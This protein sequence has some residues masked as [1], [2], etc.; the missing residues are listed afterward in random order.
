MRDFAVVQMPKINAGVPSSESYSW[1]STLRAN[2]AASQQLCRN[3]SGLHLFSQA[4]ED[5]QLLWWGEKK[6]TIN[7]AMIPPFFYILTH[8]YRT[9]WKFLSTLPN[10]SEQHYGFVPNDGCQDEVFK[11][12]LTS[13]FN[14]GTIFNACLHEIGISRLLL[15]RTGN[16][17][18]I[19]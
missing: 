17:A 13:T 16:F 5:I 18:I 6:Y 11:V 3:I 4:L 2:P 7:L 12:F 1:Y 10:R 15:T 19:E 8:T 14:D 9:F